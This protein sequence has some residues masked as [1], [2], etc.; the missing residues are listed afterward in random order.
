MIRDIE[1]QD[2]DAIAQIYN[3][4]SINK[5]T[6]CTIHSNTKKPGSTFCMR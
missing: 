4:K 1:E 2:Y 3:H 6:S 5:E